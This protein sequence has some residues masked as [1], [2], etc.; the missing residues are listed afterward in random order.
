MNKVYK[1]RQKLNFEQ[2]G[3]YYKHAYKIGVEHGKFEERE[4]IIKLL[5]DEEL[6]S[7]LENPM[8]NYDQLVWL[9]M[10]EQL[11]DLI[12]GEQK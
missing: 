8:K 5:E 7:S 9:G 1:G 11:I 2:A 4:R 10:K 12:K 3:Y 6:V